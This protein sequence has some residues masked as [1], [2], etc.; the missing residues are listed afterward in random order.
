MGKLFHQ[1]IADGLPAYRCQRAIGLT[2]QAIHRLH[3]IAHCG[4]APEGRRLFGERYLLLGNEELR[5]DP[6]S[7]LRS[8]YGALGR[9]PPASVTSWAGDAVRPAEEPFEASHPAW[10]AAFARV[11]LK[12]AL[13]AAGYAELASVTPELDFGVRIAA[14]ASRARRRLARLAGR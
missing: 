5:A 3:R 14:G 2:Q 8:V 13:A 1:Q 12:D 11:G 4:V 6:K 7:A 10:A 9:E